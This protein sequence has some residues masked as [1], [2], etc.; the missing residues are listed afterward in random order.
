M[1]RTIENCT[2]IQKGVKQ[3]LGEPNRF[4]NV[5]KCEGYAKSEYDDEP[6]KQCKECKYCIFKEV[7]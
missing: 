7:I 2:L 5:N 6:N 1:Q 4:Y 3:G